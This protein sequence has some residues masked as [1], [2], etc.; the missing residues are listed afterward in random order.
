MSCISS[1][2]TSASPCT[3]PRMQSQNTPCQNQ[4]NF[5]HHNNAVRIDWPVPS[6]DMSTIEHVK[7]FF[8]K[9]SL[10]HNT[11]TKQPQGPQCGVTGGIEADP[12]VPNHQNYS[13]HETSASPN[14]ADWR[15]NRYRRHS[16]LPN[17]I[18]K[19]ITLVS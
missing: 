9:E 3:K 19:A 16:H 17:V 12:L 14:A 1:A 2:R 15:Q 10:I 5:F 18:F 11:V 8:E 13:E 7:E 4:Q 6:S